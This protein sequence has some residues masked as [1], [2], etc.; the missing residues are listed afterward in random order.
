VVERTVPQLQERTYEP[1]RPVEV[2]QDGRWVP[3]LQ[4]AWH[5]WDDDR[6]W[7]ADVELTVTYVWGLR[8]RSVVVPASQVRL[9]EPAEPAGRVS[10][11]P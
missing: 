5:R 4:R 9:R 2:E 7:V 3:G 1:P 8:T 6:G 11:A 10:A